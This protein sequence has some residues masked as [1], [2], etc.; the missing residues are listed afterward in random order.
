METRSHFGDQT[1]DVVTHERTYHA[2]S[3]LIRW[4]MLL[5]GDA[6]LSLTLWFATPAGFWGAL[7]VGLG[8]FVLGYMFLIHREEK[9]PLDIWVEGR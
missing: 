2:F 6:I 5:L 3:I 8:V 7:V 9:Q 1:V 4:S